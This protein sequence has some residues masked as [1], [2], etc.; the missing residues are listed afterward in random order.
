MVVAALVWTQP[1]A[2]RADEGWE[3]M[4]RGDLIAAHAFW[5]PRADAGDPS[6]MSGL[7]HIAAVQGDHE[8]AAQWLHL[9]AARGQLNAM[10]L[11][12][13]AYLEGRGVARDP[14][15]AYA[16]YH[17]A[18]IRD[19][20]NAARARDLAGRWLTDEQAAEARGLAERWRIDGPPE[21]P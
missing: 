14:V 21:S 8:A 20:A 15:R 18:A 1:A 19:R 9:A 17:L 3:H 4:E 10:I 13:S 16:W 6:A 11:L 7:A 12:G 5:R 2:S